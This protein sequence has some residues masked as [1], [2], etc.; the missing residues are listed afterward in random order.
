MRR[1]MTRSFGVCLG[2]VLVLFIVL[3][4]LLGVSAF[5]T[6]PIPH[7]FWGNVEIDGQP[8]LVGTM[9]EAKCT[10]VVTGTNNPIATIEIGKYGGPSAGKLLVQGNIEYRTPIAFYLNGGR[11]KCYNPETQEWSDTFKFQSEALTELDLFFIGQ[12]TLTVTSAGC[13]PISV[14]YDTITATVAAGAIGTFT[15]ITGG[16]T[17]T[18]EATSDDYCWFDGWEGDVVTT[19]NSVTI[20]MYSDVTVTA[21]CTILTEHTLTVRKIGSGT[22]ITEPEQEIYIYGTVVTLTA[23]PSETWTFGGWSGD[24]PVE[25]S[26][27]DSITITMDS[28]KEITATFDFYSVTISSP[29]YEK[30]GNAGGDPVVY[31]LQVINTGSVMDTF[32]VTAA[33]SN[34]W[35]VIAQ[36]TVGPLAAAGAEWVFVGPQIPADTISGTVDVVTFAVTS[37]GDPRKAAT[38]LLTTTVT[39]GYVPEHKFFLPLVMKN[40]TGFAGF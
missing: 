11:A 7:A 28:D 16:L 19:A 31:M 1:T 23:T 15:T 24:V 10:G 2:L 13:C 30:P 29:A 22:V 40:A 20:P 5:A 6:P 12:Y 4:G 38:A 25:L 18:L 27:I 14:T 39:Q 17:V 9:V 8:A 32:T 34:G 21:T 36:P 35:T 3:Y 37:Q 26:A 33:S